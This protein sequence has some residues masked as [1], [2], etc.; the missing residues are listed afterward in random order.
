MLLSL[1]ILMYAIPLDF[2]TKVV[3]LYLPEFLCGI[4]LTKETIRKFNVLGGTFVFLLMVTLRLVVYYGTLLDCLIVLFIILLYKNTRRKQ[5]LSRVFYYIGKNSM[6]IFLFHTFILHIWFTDFVYS[7][8]N[9]IIIF[10]L[11]LSLCIVIAEIINGLKRHLKYDE[12]IIM[13]ERKFL[14][15]D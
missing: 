9:P 2:P 8:R 15:C 14:S 13:A 5:L 1:S 11:L 12:L 3:W 6:M 4:Y 10:F 7:S